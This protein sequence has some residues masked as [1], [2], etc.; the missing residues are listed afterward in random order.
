MGHPIKDPELDAKVRS[1]YEAG[2][3][4]RA[5]AREC[6]IGVNRVRRICG[7]PLPPSQT[8]AA[9]AAKRA[10]RQGDSA[11]A[12]Q[13]ETKPT[14][15]QK[16]QPR[17]NNQKTITIPLT[18]GAYDRLAAIAGTA[19]LS[20]EAFAATLIASYLS[21]Q[22]ARIVLD[23]SDP[24]AEDE[25][26]APEEEEPEAEEAPEEEESEED[27]P[28]KDEPEEDE[29]FVFREEDFDWLK[30][31]SE[32]VV[33]RDGRQTDVRCVS[34]W[35]FEPNGERT[36]SADGRVHAAGDAIRCVAVRGGFDGERDYYPEEV[37]FED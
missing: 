19:Y 18:A 10:Q 21:Y 17:M 20:P 23:P 4:I 25:E 16:E 7:R 26:A 32:F 37:V 36:P 35:T 27:E 13:P 31:E 14:T 33:L 30:P 2:A 9:K 6:G 1:M 8:A 5:I 11:N 22:P 24:D 15:T 12:Q 3:A 28:E 29:G 34:V